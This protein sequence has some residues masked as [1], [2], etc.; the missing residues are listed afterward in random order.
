MS[1]PC[2]DYNGTNP[3]RI[4]NC[5]TYADTLLAVHNG[6]IDAGIPYG[7]MLIDS[8]WYG[9]RVF[10]GQLTMMLVCAVANV[11]TATTCA[12]IL[13]QSI[14]STSNCRT[15][16]IFTFTF[17]AACLHIHNHPHHCLPLQGCGS[18]KMIQRS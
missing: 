10:K 11:T 2:A 8:W 1:H 7:H 3:T 5:T 17:T 14:H 4:P 12:H 16:F 6:L 13:T 18:G 9:E 15:S